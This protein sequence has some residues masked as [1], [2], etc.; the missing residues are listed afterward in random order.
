LVGDERHLVF[1]C[2]A[3]QHVRHRFSHLFTDNMPTMAS[4]FW[5]KNMRDVVFFVLECLAVL[6]S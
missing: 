5:Q 1:E 2:P 4:F 3:L 6:S